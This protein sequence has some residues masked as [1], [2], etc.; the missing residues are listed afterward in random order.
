MLGKRLLVFM[1][2]AEAETARK[3][4]LFDKANDICFVAKTNAYALPKK[5]KAVNATLG[6]FR[7]QYQDRLQDLFL[8]TEVTN[9][10]CIAPHTLEG[11]YWL[12]H[13]HHW[14][15]ANDSTGMHV[16]FVTYN[17]AGSDNWFNTTTDDL[18]SEAKLAYIYNL[19]VWNQITASC[20]YT[21]A[22]KTVAGTL[23]KSK[24]SAFSFGMYRCLAA[25]AS[26]PNPR[27]VTYGIT[28]RDSDGE[29]L[30]TYFFDP[31]DAVPLRNIGVTK[32]AYATDTACITTPLKFE[33]TSN[34]TDT[35]VDP[36][37]LFQ[38]PA[39]PGDS[40]TKLIEAYDPYITCLLANLPIRKY[41]DLVHFGYLS[42]AC[43]F[44]IEDLSVR[45]PCAYNGHMRKVVAYI[46]ELTRQ[47]ILRIGSGKTYATNVLSGKCAPWHDTLVLACSTE[48]IMECF[49]Y[50]VLYDK[51]QTRTLVRYCEYPMQNTVRLTG[52]AAK[53]NIM[54]V[55]NTTTAHVPAVDTSAPCD[56][57]WLSVV[58]SSAVLKTPMQFSEDGWLSLDARAEIINSPLALSNVFNVL[59]SLFGYTPSYVYSVIRSLSRKGCLEIT[60]HGVNLTAY[61]YAIGTAMSEALNHGSG[62]EHMDALDA[63]HVELT[64]NALFNPITVGERPADI[65]PLL[66]K[67][68]SLVLE[69][70]KQAKLWKSYKV[71]VKKKKPGS[72]VPKKYVYRLCFDRKAKHAWFET[73]KHKRTFIHA[74]VLEVTQ[75]ISFGASRVTHSLYETKL[76][77]GS[78]G[79]LKSQVLESPCPECGTMAYTYKRSPD[80][81][82]LLLKCNGCSGTRPAVFQIIDTSINDPLQ[83]L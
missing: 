65:L 45:L 34:T 47:G 11:L 76:V 55:C 26:F 52:Y 18:E 80:K 48:K 6:D 71:T 20:M 27:S 14:R 41:W 29:S 16:S 73:R 5:C 82:R 81:T 32:Y 74:K 42:I 21:S 1:T 83:N 57:G 24:K 64:E 3:Q 72:K 58:D 13:W 33:K 35:V 15:E 77:P 68:K 28:N 53:G 66:E 4:Q 56:L 37:S 22:L 63:M 44:N 46:D 12:S 7:F 78:V 60:N 31:Y 39:V 36:A 43:S 54:E 40:R 62:K 70:A 67:A 17:V 79:L 49:D 10:R 75:S 59:E 38:S 2:D 19:Y 61:G 51:Y 25:L 8:E 9:I 50:S 30:G 23:L 69:I